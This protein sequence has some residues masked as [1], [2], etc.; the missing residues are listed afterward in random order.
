MEASGSATNMIRSGTEVYFRYLPISPRLALWGVYV[1]GA[2]CS[3]IPPH[4]AYPPAGHPD[5]YQFTWTKGRVLPEYQIVYI[6]RGKGVFESTASG[7]ISV[8]AGDVLVLFPGIWHRYRPS[9][10]TGWKTYWVGGDGEHLHAMVQQGFLSPERPVLHMGT[11]PSALDPFVRI[12]SQVQNVVVENP[13]L[14][15]VNMMEVIARISVP[16]RSASADPS[17]QAIVDALETQD[18]LVA[19]AVRFIWN[20][21]QRSLSVKDVVAKVPL[22]RRSL[23]RRFLQAMGRTI[24]EEIARCRIERVKRT[25]EETV[26]PIKRVA[27]LTGFSSAERL[28]KV[29]HKYEGLSPLAYRQQNRQS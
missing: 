5:L 29:F 24:H 17:T 19:E 26:L 1:T 7:E 16:L 6:A 8:S 18:R 20:A 9:D 25:L 2:G 15:A 28:C 11:S 4:T 10:A 12:L 22:A 23:E 3:D 14:L 21:D 27:L 13:L